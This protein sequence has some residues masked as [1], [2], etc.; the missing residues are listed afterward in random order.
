MKWKP[1]LVTAGIA[2]GTIILWQFVRPVAQR[3]PFVGSY[4]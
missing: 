3:L 1:I 2:L 4:L